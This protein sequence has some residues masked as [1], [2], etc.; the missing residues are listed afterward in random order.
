MSKEKED[1]ECVEA[2]RRGKSRKEVAPP[3]HLWETEG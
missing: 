2:E 1:I 3:R